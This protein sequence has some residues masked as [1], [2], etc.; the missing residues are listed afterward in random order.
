MKFLVDAQLPPALCRWIEA[1]GHE[2]SHVADL[3]DQP[4]PDWLIGDIAERDG[5]ILII[6][7]GAGG[8]DGTR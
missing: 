7:D 4:V 6:K 5:A 8:G 2:A 1:R 3:P